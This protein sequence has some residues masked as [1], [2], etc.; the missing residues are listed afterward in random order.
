MGVSGPSTV[1]GQLWQPTQ[2]YQDT[3]RSEDPGDV[4]DLSPHISGCER[5]PGGG[6]DEGHPRREAQCDGGEPHGC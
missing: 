3:A 2:V 1:Q 6:G 5:R 4:A